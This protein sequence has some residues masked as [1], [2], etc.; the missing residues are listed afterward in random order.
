MR[1]VLE[2]G[3]ALEHHLLAGEGLTPSRAFV[4][5]LFLT[6]IFAIPGAKVVP[7]FQIGRGHRE[8]GVEHGGDPAAAEFR[9]SRR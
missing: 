6:T 8:E 3:L 1:T 7:F 2:A 9:C 4:A 5:G